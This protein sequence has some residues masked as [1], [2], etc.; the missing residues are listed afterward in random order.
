M[1]VTPVPPTSVVATARV[2]EAVPLLTNVSTAIAPAIGSWYFQSVSVAAALDSGRLN[3]LLSFSN[4]SLGIL[5]GTTA[6][7]IYASNTSGSRGVTYSHAQSA[8]IY[9]MDD[10]TNSTRLTRV[11][12]N[13]WPVGISHTVSVST[14]NVSQLSI[15]I[16]AQ[17]AYPGTVGTNG[18]Y[19]MTTVPASHLQA[20]AASSVCTS[21]MTSGLSTLFNVLSGQLQ[22]PVG[23]NTALSPGNYW[24][25][26]GWSSSSTTGGSSIAVVW[27]LVNQ[28][29]IP[30]NT[31]LGPYR[32]FGSTASTAG[33]YVM[34][35]NGAF[36]AVSAAPPAT[37]AFSDIRSIASNNSQYFNIMQS[38]ASST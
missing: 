13:S 1:A 29:M 16:S 27:P 9:R 5:N 35:G 37:I 14:S 2:F 15:N 20:T 28:V 6:G 24:L 25:G 8:A 17:I 33:S 38:A 3:M 18:A 11:W 10:G 23:F 19:T 12:S 34:P 30:G 31:A 32:M 26:A 7:S 21:A 36:T 4:S 22:M